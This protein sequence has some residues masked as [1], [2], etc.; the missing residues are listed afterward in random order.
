MRRIH[1]ATPRL[2]SGTACADRA[3][4]VRLNRGRRHIR[5]PAT[6]P[7]PLW[8]SG[9]A[10]SDREHAGLPPARAGRRRD[11]GPGGP[12]VVWRALRRVIRVVDVLICQATPPKP[13]RA[14]FPTDSLSE[15]GRCEASNGEALVCPAGLP[16][17]EKGGSRA[18][19]HRSGPVRGQRDAS[20][21]TA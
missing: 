21:M 20:K 8:P 3:I 5:Y 12:T 6:A 11:H 7:R 10:G 16:P 18:K 1:R 4:C 15:K 13:G 14:H 2:Y 17:P 9:P 19:S